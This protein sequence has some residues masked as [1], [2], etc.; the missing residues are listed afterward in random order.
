[1]AA[2]MI[3][4]GGVLQCI[5]LAKDGI[6]THLYPLNQSEVL[7]HTM[8]DKTERG[9]CAHKAME[10]GE[11]TIAGPFELIQGGTGALLLDPIYTTDA[12]SNKQFWGFSL[13]VI[14]WEKFV[15]ELQ[16]NKLEE[17]SYRF[18]IWKKD[19]VTGERVCIA[20]CNT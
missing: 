10:S 13:L 5:G 12:S 16:L 1:M 6:V 3:D 19:A 14:D 15:D 20:Q 11:Y 9:A 17:A 2:L 8:F 7:G 18:R 4:D